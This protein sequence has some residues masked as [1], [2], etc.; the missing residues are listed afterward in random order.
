LID[1]LAKLTTLSNTLTLL[2][3]PLAL[4]F[5]IQSSYIRIIALFLAIATDGL[6]GYFARRYRTVSKFGTV[7]DPMMDRFFVLFVL[8]TFSSEGVIS[9]WQIIAML[10]R[11]I[12][13]VLSVTYVRLFGDWKNS[14]AKATYWGKITTCAQFCVLIALSLGAVVPWYVFSLFFLFGIFFAKEVY[15]HC[16][17]HPNTTLIS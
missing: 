16:Q 5:L 15:T 8:L 7:L 17:S 9:G 11:D 13:L 14:E 3:A 6:D 12:A 10:S 4:L 1:Q 2:R